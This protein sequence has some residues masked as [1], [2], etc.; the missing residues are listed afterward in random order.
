MSSLALREL[1]GRIAGMMS[2]FPRPWFLCGG[3]A[4]DSWLGHQTRDH[5]DVDICIFDADQGALFDHLSGW[6]MT[7]HNKDTT[8]GIWDGRPLALPAHIHARP[9]GEDN[10]ALVSGWLSTGAAWAAHD[11]FDV[12]FILNARDGGEWTLSRSPVVSRPLVRCYRDSPA[13]IPT[14]QPEVLMFYKATAY[15]G[16]APTS[17]EAIKGHPRP[18]DLVD[19]LALA[20]LLAA[21]EE[22]WL[23]EALTAIDPRHPWLGHLAG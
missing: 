11:G 19:F 23:V 5:G 3:W 22:R 6:F 7:G 20:P 16:P 2:S 8:S 1:S 17:G 4:A 13:G 12:E 14:A 18:H 15:W 21:A 9:P 10:R